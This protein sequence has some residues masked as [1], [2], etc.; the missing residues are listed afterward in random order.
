MSEQTQQASTIVKKLEKYVSRRS[1]AAFIAVSFFVLVS[2]VILSASQASQRVMLEVSNI[3]N[4]QR[5]LLTEVSDKIIFLLKNS[6][7]KTS[8]RFIKSVQVDITNKVGELNNNQERLKLSLNQQSNLTDIWPLHLL[9]PV[10][11]QVTLIDQIGQNLEEMTGNVNKLIEA[12][13]VIVKA[14]FSFWDPSYLTIVRDGKHTE[15]MS[16]LNELIYTTALEYNKNLANLHRYLLLVVILGIWLIWVYILKPLANQVNY[17]FNI[18]Q[19]NQGELRHQARYDSMTGL[20]NRQ[21]FS[22]ITERSSHE[23]KLS[24]HVAAIIID[25]DEFKVINDSFGHQA[26]DLILQETAKRLQQNATESEQAKQILKAASE[27]HITPDVAQMFVNM[28]TGMLKIEE[29]TEIKERLDR[30]EQMI[31]NNG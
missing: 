23:E 30:M 22:S 5:I 8:E 17:Q 28:M 16:E 18:I 24:S 19:Q 13:P 12:D 2:A 1:L 25:V 15:Q 4:D 3:T 10:E 14:G 26:G 11:K 9:Y 27:G 29:V 21:S 6:S 31:E 20:M 7:Q